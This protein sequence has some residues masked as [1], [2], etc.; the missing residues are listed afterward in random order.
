ML[1][2]EIAHILS[3]DKKKIALIAKQIEELSTKIA[4]WT[5]DST[6]P[7]FDEDLFSLTTHI[8]SPIAQFP[9]TADGYARFA[10]AVDASVQVVKTELKKAFHKPLIGKPLTT[11]EVVAKSLTELTGKIS[12]YFATI[13]KIVA[14]VNEI[15][16]DLTTAASCAAHVPKGIEDFGA[17]VTGTKPVDAAEAAAAWKKAG[18]AASGFVSAIIGKSSGGSSAAAVSHA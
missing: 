17:G 11:P 5:S 7:L 4:A 12:A 18:N 10:D 9:V 14:G 16:R 13:D 1:F 15:V 2:Q 6:D 3:F 8:L